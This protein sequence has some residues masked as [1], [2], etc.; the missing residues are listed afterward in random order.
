[1]KSLLAL[2][3]AM[4]LVGGLVS[5]ESYLKPPSRNS[6]MRIELTTK[7]TSWNPAGTG[8]GVVG[9]NNGR[10][11]DGFAFGVKPLTSYTIIYYGYNGQND[12]WPV[13]TCIS[14]ATSWSSGWVSF[15]TMSFD[16]RS[17]YNDGIN[18]KFWIVPTADLDCVNHQFIAWNPSGIL[19]EQATV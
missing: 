15:P 10:T 13:A 4:L 17:F 2:F 16:Y 19:F 3:V 14:T 18:Q 1:M 9:G 7:D 6:L 5:A 8:R 11:I 12:V